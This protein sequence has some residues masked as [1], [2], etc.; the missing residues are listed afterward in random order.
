MEVYYAAIEELEDEALAQRLLLKLPK[1]RRERILRCHKQVDMQRSLAAWTLFTMAGR[2]FLM[3]R[4]RRFSVIMRMENR[5]WRGIPGILICPMPEIM[6]WQHL[7]MRRSAWTLSR[8]EGQ[9]R[10]LR[11]AFYGRGTGNARWFTG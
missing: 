9:K 10:R 5:M 2:G 6:R 11:N 4:R 1:D 8:W 7:Q 3:L